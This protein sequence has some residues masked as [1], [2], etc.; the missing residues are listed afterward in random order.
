[1]VGDFADR[2]ENLPEIDHGI[3]GRRCGG[4]PAVGRRGS[5]RDDMGGKDVGSRLGRHIC[6]FPGH[7]GSPANLREAAGIS[8]KLWEN[9]KQSEKCWFAF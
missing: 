9:L 6:F 5:S 1:V 8:A 4:H 3:A 7:G 2:G